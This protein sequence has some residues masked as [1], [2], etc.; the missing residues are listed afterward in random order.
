[1]TRA[2]LERERRRLRDENR[3]SQWFQKR[4][5]EAREAAEKEAQLKLAR[6]K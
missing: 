1:M 6:S 5:I 3:A 2:C 4:A